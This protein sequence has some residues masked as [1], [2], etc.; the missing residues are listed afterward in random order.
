LKLEHEKEGQGNIMTDQYHVIVWIDHREA[1]IFHV[2]TSDS[3]RVVV[4]AH[5]GHHMQHKAN[6]TGS[7]HQGVDTEFFKRVI[8]ALARAGAILIAG[9]G[10]AKAEFKNYI[11]EHRAELAQRI[12]AVEALDHPSDAELIALARKFF[13]TGDR[14]PARTQ[15]SRP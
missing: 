4:S 8:E 12:S 3:D 13:K 2:D 6:V 9:P 14:M 7:G 5:G 11:A 10:N 1:K 15:A